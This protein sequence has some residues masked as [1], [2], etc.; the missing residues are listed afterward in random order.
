MKTFYFNTGVK[1][2]DY[3]YLYGSQVCRNGTKQIPFVVENPFADK[4]PDNAELL[5]CCDY[6]NLEEG[7]RPDVLVVPIHSEDIHSQY[8]YFRIS[9]DFP[10]T[11]LK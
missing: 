3:P 7:K 11:V 5:F 10:C 4:L 8:A 9:T 1:F 2:S 6:P